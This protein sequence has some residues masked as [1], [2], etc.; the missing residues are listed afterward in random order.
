MT[1][2]LIVVLHTQAGAHLQKDRL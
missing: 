1:V 2:E